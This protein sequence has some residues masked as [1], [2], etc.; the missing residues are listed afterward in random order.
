MPYPNYTRGERFG[1][2]CSDL[3]MYMPMILELVLGYGVTAIVLTLG[4]F[5]LIPGWLASPFA[6]AG[7]AYANYAFWRY[8]G[9]RSSGKR[10]RIINPWGPRGSDVGTTMLWLSFGVFFHFYHVWLRSAFAMRR[11]HVKEKLNQ[12]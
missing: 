6:I 1:F 9:W 7:W 8:Q 4:I 3:A 11:R 12:D 10:G 5:G 2:F